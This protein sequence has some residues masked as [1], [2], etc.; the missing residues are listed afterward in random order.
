[1][2]DLLEK[3]GIKEEITKLQEQW[4]ATTR[5]KPKPA[6]KR[7]NSDAVDPKDKQLLPENVAEMDEKDSEGAE[8]SGSIGYI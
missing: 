7:S 4:E 6:P 1:M 5:P 3:D 8:Q 2:S